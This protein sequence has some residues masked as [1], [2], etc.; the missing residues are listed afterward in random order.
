G[1]V[2]IWL[3]PRAKRFHPSTVM[4]LAGPLLRVPTLQLVKAY[5][6]PRQDQKARGRRQK[7]ENDK[8]SSHPREA[9]Y[10]PVDMS[11]GG[12]VLPGPD[13][14]QSAGR[15]RV[16]ALRPDD[17]QALGAAQIAS[18]PPRTILQVLCPSLA[19]VIAPFSRDF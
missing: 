14:T 4:S 13:D 11:W 19:A 10:A 7:A 18:M 17:L 3:D 15:I 8:L 12:F 1:D 9:E 6:Q 2:L 16:Q 5:G